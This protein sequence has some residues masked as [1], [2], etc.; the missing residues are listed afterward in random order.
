MIDDLGAHRD[1]GFI[2]DN[3]ETLAFFVERYHQS[4]VAGFENVPEGAALAVGNHNGGIMSPDM[5]ALMVAWWRHFGVEQ[6]AYGLAHD[7]PFMIPIVGKLLRRCGAVPARPENAIA[8]LRRGAKVLVYPGGDL[9]A[10][11]SWSRRNEIVFGERRGFVRIALRA[12]AP[13]VP[14]V[15]VGAHEAFR[16][17]TDGTKLARAIG[18]KRLTRIEVLPIVTGLPWGLWVGPGPYLPVPVR[19]R[20]KILPPISWPSLPPEAADDESIVLRCREE[21]RA[22]MQSCLDEMVREGGYGPRFHLFG[23]RSRHETG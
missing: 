4:H 2:R 3:L 22:T 5:F 14:V 12:R 20:I 6:P 15:S 7:V 19:I 16:V 9:D 11:R 1:P 10:F 13:I 17:L 23:S 8:L 18:L 21:V